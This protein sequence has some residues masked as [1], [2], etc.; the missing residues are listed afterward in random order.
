[1]LSI[2][3]H[4]IK[5]PLGIELKSEQKYEELIHV[6]RHLQQYVPT[7]TNTTEV[8]HDSEPIQI[9]TDKFHSLGLG[10]ITSEILMLAL[11]AIS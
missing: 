5:V 11:I 3:L 9:V 8:V 4:N 6:L 1:M 10:N 7:K 2:N